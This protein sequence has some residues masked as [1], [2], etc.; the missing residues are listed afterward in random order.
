M[1]S[2]CAFVLDRLTTDNVLIVVETRHF[3]PNQCGGINGWAGLKL[4]MTKA[5]DR[6]EWDFLHFMLLN[7]GFDSGWIN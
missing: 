1:D 3:L 2:Q 6:M 4:D 5:Y 7:F